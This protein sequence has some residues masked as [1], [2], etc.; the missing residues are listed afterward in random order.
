MWEVASPARQ[1]HSSHH[2]L[3]MADVRPR[4]AEHLD[5][6]ATIVKRNR[7]E[8][9][10]SWEKEGEYWY[11]VKS[12]AAKFYIVLPGGRRQLLDLLLPNDFLCSSPYS[13]H[14]CT[15]EAVVNKTVVA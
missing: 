2:D 14:Y 4:N 1:I 15:L 6:I 7:G 9:I 3:P 10:H 13:P 11:T 12:G 5:S 8:E